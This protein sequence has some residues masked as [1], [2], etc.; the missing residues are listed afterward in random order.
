[1]GHLISR[2]KNPPGLSRRSGGSGESDRQGGLLRGGPHPQ[3]G[4]PPRERRGG[5]GRNE[6]EEP[7]ARPACGTPGTAQKG[8]PLP[9]RRGKGQQ[10]APPR[11]RGAASF[12][13]VRG[14][15]PR[16]VI[17]TEWPGRVSVAR[18]S[19]ANE[20]EPSAVERVSRRPARGPGTFC[21]GPFAALLSGAT[22]GTGIGAQLRRS[23]A[24]GGRINAPMHESCEGPAAQSASLGLRVSSDQATRSSI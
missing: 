4:S 16:P 19:L 12:Q 24:C 20:S 10:P 3:P 8:A 23:V 7:A 6:E 18:R 1:M 22:A 21:S 5:K 13:P 9:T 2:P 14:H 11:P 15:R 17:V